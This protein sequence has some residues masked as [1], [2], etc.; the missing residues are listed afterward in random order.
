MRSVLRRVAWLVLLLALAGCET[1]RMQAGW[2]LA[3]PPE[4]VQNTAKLTRGLCDLPVSAGASARAEAPTPDA[5]SNPAPTDKPS[6]PPRVLLGLLNVGR[7]VLDVTGVAINPKFLAAE[8]PHWIWET[9]KALH[10]V[11]LKFKSRPGELH[12]LPLPDQT[13]DGRPCI[14]PVLVGIEYAEPSAGEKKWL[15]V[16]PAGRLPNALPLEWEP[17]ASPP[18][19]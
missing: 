18:K 3:E 13:A 14:L 19:K 9:P 16:T 10:K 6:P 2:Y 8:A 5:Q 12:V 1:P 4:P 15:W 17:S 7:L 11:S